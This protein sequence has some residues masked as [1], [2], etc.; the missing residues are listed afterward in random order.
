MHRCHQICSAIDL[1]VDTILA[2]LQQVRQ[3]DTNPPL[4]K[5]HVRDNSDLTQHI[6]WANISQNVEAIGQWESGKQLC[7]CM[8]AKGHDIEHVLN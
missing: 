4:Y 8:E 3:Q 6:T 2:D 1:I 7:A 5:T